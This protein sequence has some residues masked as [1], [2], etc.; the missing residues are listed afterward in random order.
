MTSTS[1][2]FFFLIIGIF[3][4]KNR[5]IGHQIG[6][7]HNSIF[8]NT[9]TM[10]KVSGIFFLPCRHSGNFVRCFFFVVYHL[11]ATIAQAHVSFP[12][13]VILKRCQMGV[14]EILSLSPRH[15]RKAGDEMANFKKNGRLN[16][17]LFLPSTGKQT[18]LQCTEKFAVLRKSDAI[19]QLDK[20]RGREMRKKTGSS[21]LFTLGR[22]NIFG[23]GINKDQERLDSL[24]F[25]C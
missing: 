21:I 24:Y 22:T 19:I 20:L 25:S 10:S 11:W 13:K 5:S 4:F 14:K 12:Q 7:Q 18:F 23:I 16:V 3:N 6:P 1:K 2:N 17:F 9:I 15:E 8:N